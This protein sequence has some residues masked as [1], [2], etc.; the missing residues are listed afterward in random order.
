MLCLFYTVLKASLALLCVLPIP[1][2]AASRSTHPASPVP[3]AS[4]SPHRATIT[5]VK[6]A[7][8]LASALRSNVRHV[9]LTAHVDLRGYASSAP[10]AGVIFE[11]GSRLESLTVREST[12][13]DISLTGI[14]AYVCSNGALHRCAK[15]D[16]LKTLVKRRSSAC[17][18]YI[19]RDSM[20]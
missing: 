13:K 6:T 14:R 9:R 10:E 20:V 1:A 16:L 2:A 8:Q 7:D 11:A 17:C 15:D 12:T 19:L 4:Y 3:A 5:V 18:R